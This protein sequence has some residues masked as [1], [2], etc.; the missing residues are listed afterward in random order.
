MLKSLQETLSPESRCFVC[1]PKN[2][3]GFRIRSFPDPGSPDAVLCDWTPERRHEAYPGI[4]NGGVA[5]A[6]LDCH[7]NW[8][9][10]RH[11]MRRDGL[12]AAPPTVT[13]SLEFRYRRP[14]S[15]EGPLRLW[16]QALSS[17]GPSVRVEGRILAAGKPTVLAA[18]RIVA[19]PPDHPALRKREP[20]L[21]KP[22]C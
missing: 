15:T 14:T 18:G 21:G 22:L 17:D 7:L 20:P 5:A 4:L 16:A 10:V 11:L 9:A 3:E 2:A 19:V 1:G 6:L 8:A 13:A 12:A